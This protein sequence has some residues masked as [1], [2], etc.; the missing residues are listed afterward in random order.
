MG[1]LRSK[2]DYDQFV[3]K[4]DPKLFVTEHHAGRYDVYRKSELGCVPPHF[5]L[6]L[7]DDWTPRTHPV[8]WGLVPL[9]NKFVAIDRW[10]DDSF[11]HTLDEE[12]AEV[13]AARDRNFRNTTEDFFR[14]FRRQ[15][16]RATDGINTSSL[17]KIYRDEENKDGYC[18]S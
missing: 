10:R 17:K 16:A 18:K 14:D 2:T 11:L 5:V 1:Y 4:I 12:N 9:W 7:T 8:P 6:S 3:K 15:F 13:S